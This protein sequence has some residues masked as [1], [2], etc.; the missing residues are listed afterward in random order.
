MAFFLFLE[1][2]KTAQL[3]AWGLIA[4]SGRVATLRGCDRRAQSEL[5]SLWPIWPL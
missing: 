3:S 5:C 1:E 2:Q 4:S